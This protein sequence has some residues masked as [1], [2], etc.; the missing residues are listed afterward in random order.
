MR[1][2]AGRTHWVY[3][4][5]EMYP[6]VAQLNTPPELSVT[7]LKRFWSQEITGPQVVEACRRRG[8]EQLLLNP[9]QTGPEWDALL[10][11]YDPVYKD[12]N[13]VLYVAKRIEN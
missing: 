9:A 3:A 13:F 12:T 11:D 4:A 8:A 7:V 1:Q 10:G 2:Y 5:Q 6:F